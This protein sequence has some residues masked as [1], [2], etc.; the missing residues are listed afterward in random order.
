[1][2][3]NGALA[4]YLR[5]HL[6]GS[7]G[8]ASLARR[9]A[10][11]SDDPSAHE[12]MEAIAAEIEADQRALRALMGRLEV[13][14]SNFKRATAWAGEKLG[15]LKLNTSREDRRLLQYEAMIMGVTG[16]LEL[17]R[18]LEGNVDA[19][20]RLARDELSELARRAEDQRSRLEALHGRAA[21]ALLASD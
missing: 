4:T 21:A 11:G 2:A 1:V 12:E 10:S 18:G 16:K 6:A 20:P 19:D 5:D 13:R 9:I 3:T 8:G 7:A 15:A 17:W 14:P